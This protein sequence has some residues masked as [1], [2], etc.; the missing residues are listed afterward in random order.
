MWR[1]QL[2]LPVQVGST[3]MFRRDEFHLQKTYETLL[4][5]RSINTVVSTYSQCYYAHGYIMNFS[6]NICGHCYGDRSCTW[7]S[8]YSRNV[9]S[10][11]LTIHMHTQGLTLLSYYFRNDADN[12][13]IHLSKSDY[14]TKYYRKYKKT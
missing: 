6:I 5:K 10:R 1:H 2:R 14:G 3:K 13:V 11:S 9:T 8:Q 12:R 4:I 7:E